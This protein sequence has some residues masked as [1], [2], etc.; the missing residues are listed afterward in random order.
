MSRLRASGWLWV[1]LLLLAAQTAVTQQ[2]KGPA[3][4]AARAAD[5]EQIRKAVLDFV[6]LYNAHKAGD[7]AALFAA[8]ARVAY[9]DGTEDNGREEIKQS[10]EEAFSANP[11]I[12]MS[13][14]VEEI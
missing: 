14:V 8:D 3:T 12:A 5:E 1:V 9:R 13:V 6:E 4:A 10:F 7:V 11:K 2:P